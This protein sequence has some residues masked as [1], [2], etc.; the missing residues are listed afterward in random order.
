LFLSDDRIPLID[1]QQLLEL[2][3]QSRSINK[4]GPAGLLGC[5]ALL[6]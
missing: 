4:G 5:R 3:E 2:S 6:G 1:L